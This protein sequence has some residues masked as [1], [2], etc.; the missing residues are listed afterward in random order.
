MRM[1]ATRSFAYNNK[2]LLTENNA[3]NNSKIITKMMNFSH[4]LIFVVSLKKSISFLI[5]N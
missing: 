3:E 2:N 5:L 4:E 1:F